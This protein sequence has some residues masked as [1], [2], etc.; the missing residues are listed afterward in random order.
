MALREVVRSK[1]QSE[2]LSELITFVLTLILSSFLLRFMW[3]RS[4][5]PHIS[6][7]KPIGNLADAFLLSMS[8]SVL[9]CC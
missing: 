5:V 8:L 3:N 6:A 4:L 1:S 9:K 7:L 2:L